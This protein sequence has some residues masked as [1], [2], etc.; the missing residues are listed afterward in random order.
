MIIGRIYFPVSTL[1][2]GK[3]IGIWLCGCKRSCRNCISPELQFR[4]NG[5]EMTAENLMIIL[6][7]YLPEADGIT[8]SG[9][10]P[11]EQAQEV[12]DLMQLFVQSGKD[13][14]LLYTGFSLEELEEHGDFFQLKCLE[15]AAAVVFDP[16][17]DEL[18]DGIG[19]RGSSNQRIMINRCRERHE[20]LWSQTRRLQV[21]QT[22]KN[23]LIIGI[24]ERGNGNL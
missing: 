8:I 13:D 19:I 15:M 1:G 10:E 20:K 17:V 24:P 23:M 9:G 4:E 18:N 14:I 7:K 12:W 3:R 2:Y 5:K 16:Y 21:I 6:D 11:L 22:E